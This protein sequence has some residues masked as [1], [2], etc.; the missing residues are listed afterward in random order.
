[1]TQVQAPPGEQLLFQAV[2]DALPMSLHVIDR[3]FRIVVWN[4]RR[5]EGPFGRPR[6][7]VLGRDLFA[8]IG[9]DA[10][11]RR[12]YEQIFAGGQAQ[13]SEVVS[14]S[15]CGPRIFSVEKV[16]MRVGEGEE[17]SHVITFARDITR[18]RALERAVV[19][20]EKMAAIGQLTAGIAHE[21]N[22]PLAT[23][24]GCA[25]SM[26]SRLAEAVND[27]E[28]S[29]IQ[30]DA[31]VIEEEA[32]RLKGVLQNLLEL[33]RRGPADG[34]AYCDPC[35]VAERTVNLVRHNPAMAGITLELECAESV[36][37]VSANEDHL[38]QVMLALLSNAADAVGKDGRVRVDVRAAGDDEVVLS[39]EDDGP[40]VPPEIRD[41]VFEPFFTT[42]PPGEGT[43]LGLAV[44][45]GLVQAHG[46]RLELASSSG[47]GTC[48]D[49]RLPVASRAGAESE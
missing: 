45:Y 15:G 2:V 19:Q 26:R 14:H 46:G 39:V 7:E 47:R 44:A 6:G 40:G 3:D 38:V 27:A 12:E 31:L 24:A 41:R 8:V 30:E 23:I 11:I 20:S 42:K 25:E 9:E 1:M 33:S 21:I 28:R 48:F 22:N 4:R 5:E 18:Q 13:V 29:E 37:P 49:V 43:G 36:P 34:P 10:A 17:I 35:R 16:P 32:Y